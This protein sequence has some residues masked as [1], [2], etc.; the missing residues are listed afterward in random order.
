MA[1]FAATPARTVAFATLFRFVI[2]PLVSVLG[3]VLSV[4]PAARV[5]RGRVAYIRRSFTGWLVPRP[6]A[7]DRPSG[8]DWATPPIWWLWVAA[9]TWWARHTF[10]TRLVL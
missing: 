6:D 9:G 8:P 3:D 1:A 10:A 2:I 4:S 5:L 7:R